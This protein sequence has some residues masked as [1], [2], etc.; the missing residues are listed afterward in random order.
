MVP[1][2]RLSN[3][4]LAVGSVFSPDLVGVPVYYGESRVPHERTMLKLHVSYFRSMEALL[5]VLVNNLVASLNSVLDVTLIYSR[6]WR[7]FG[8]QMVNNTTTQPI[9]TPYCSDNK[10]LRS[11]GFS[12]TNPFFSQQYL[13]LREL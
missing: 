12:F 1:N 13:P 3:R 4:G 7:R 9:F 11:I 10:K 2:R 8:P 6:A 5:I